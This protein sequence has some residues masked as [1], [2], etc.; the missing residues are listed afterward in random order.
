MRLCWGLSLMLPWSRAL[1]QRAHRGPARRAS[2]ELRR[3]RVVLQA[4]TV[5]SPWARYVCIH[6]RLMSWT[7][8]LW[9]PTRW[10]DRAMATPFGLLPGPAAVAP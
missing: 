6:K 7:L 1:S 5:S 10:V 2:D 4:L 9:L 8:P 3:S